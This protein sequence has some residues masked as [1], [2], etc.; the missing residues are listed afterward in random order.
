MLAVRNNELNMG[1]NKLDMG[2]SEV[3]KGRGTCGEAR[4]WHVDELLSKLGLVSWKARYSW[5]PR[6]WRYLVII[7][8]LVIFAFY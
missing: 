4:G 3:A 2:G 5:G 1:N 6:V 7:L 8:F